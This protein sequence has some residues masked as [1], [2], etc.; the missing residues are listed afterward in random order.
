MEL[1]TM[2]FKL[3]SKDFYKTHLSF[4][5]RKNQIGRRM[6]FAPRRKYVGPLYV[7]TMHCGDCVPLTPRMHSTFASSS[8]DRQRVNPL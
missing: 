5:A 8:Q 4:V 6:G 7:L 1:L 2:T 3:T